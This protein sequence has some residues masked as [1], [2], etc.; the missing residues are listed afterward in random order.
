MTDFNSILN[1]QAGQAERPKTPPVGT[2]VGFIKN[3][4]FGESAQK[5]TK[6]VRFN[7]VA[8]QPQPDVD[9]QLFMDFGGSEALGKAKL[10]VDFY[11]TPDAL[12]RLDEFLMSLGIELSGRTYKETLPETAQK[13][14]QFHVSHQASNKPGSTDVF[15]NVDQIMAM[16]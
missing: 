10:R 9:E 2:Y 14:I 12:Y 13:A 4:E 1:T 16:A 5:K 3:Y 6:Y 7:L 8:S 11:L 15:A